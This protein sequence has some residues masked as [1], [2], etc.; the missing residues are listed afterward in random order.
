M[1][2]LSSSQAGLIPLLEFRISHPPSPVLRIALFSFPLATIGLFSGLTD[3]ILLFVS[4]FVFSTPCV[5][6]VR[7]YLSFS[8]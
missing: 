7:C 6:D 5:T 4:S 2:C 3:L 1:L 8:D